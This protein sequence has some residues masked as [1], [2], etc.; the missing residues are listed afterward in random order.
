M[1]NIYD[2]Q[3]YYYVSGL[4]MWKQYIQALFSLA[5]SLAESEVQHSK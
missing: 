3:K 4:Q 5:C 2:A 1:L